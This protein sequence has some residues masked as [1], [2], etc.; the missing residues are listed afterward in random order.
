MGMESFVF[1][2]NRNHS[3]NMSKFV[4]C[5]CAKEIRQYQQSGPQPQL[6]FP[7]RLAPE[8]ITAI[9]VLLL[10]SL[11]LPHSNELVMYHGFY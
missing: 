5:K 4:L 10:L 8:I 3:P 2:I 1:N 11:R 6:Q 7:V 9:P